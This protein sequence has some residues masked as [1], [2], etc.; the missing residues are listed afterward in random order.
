MTPEERE[1]HS[2]LGDGVY[3]EST[4]YHIILRTGDHRDSHCDNKIYL[5]KHVFINFTEWLLN[6]K[7]MN[8]P[9]IVRNV[10]LFEFFS[11]LGESDEKVQRMMGMNDFTKEELEDIHTCVDYALTYR[12]CYDRMYLLIDKLS[13]MIENYCEHDFN[14]LQLETIDKIKSMLNDCH[15]IDIIIRHNGKDKLFEADFLKQLMRNKGERG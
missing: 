8:A 9:S 11:M 5:E 4:P 10:N 6:I 15:H 12:D 14:K 1:N 7:R 3:A 2:Y 13:S